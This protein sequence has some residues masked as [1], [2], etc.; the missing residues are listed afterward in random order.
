MKNICGPIKHYEAGKL[1]NHQES[2][3]AFTSDQMRRP[4]IP[5]E[6]FLEVNKY[7]SN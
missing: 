7:L 5:N 2:L 3:V 4:E 6:H 1:Q